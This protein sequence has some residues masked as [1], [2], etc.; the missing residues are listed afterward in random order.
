M[1]AIADAREWADQAVTE[2]RQ[3]GKGLIDSQRPAIHDAVPGIADRIAERL[4]SGR[5]TS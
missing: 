3:E 5:A 4:R 2:V 1:Q